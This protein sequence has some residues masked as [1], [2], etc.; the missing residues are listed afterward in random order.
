MRMGIFLIIVFLSGCVKNF[1]GPDGTEWY[2]T[3]CNSNNVTYCYSKAGNKCPAGYD[4]RQMQQ[5]GETTSLTVYSNLNSA[6]V[7]RISE[8]TMIFK[9]K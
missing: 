2:S 7:H 4:I 5:S 8:V 3:E 1:V 6:D 9:C